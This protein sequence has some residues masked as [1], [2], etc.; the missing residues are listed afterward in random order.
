M[1]LKSKIKVFVYEQ[2]SRRWQRQ[3]H[4]GNVNSSL[5]ELIKAENCPYRQLP[6][7]FHAG[8]INNQMEHDRML[9]VAM[10]TVDKGDQP[11]EAG[12]VRGDT[13]MDDFLLCAVV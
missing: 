10:D 6:Q 7:V 2:Q 8:L 4:Q 12:L 3:Q 1:C 13:D 5:L 11:S 9:G